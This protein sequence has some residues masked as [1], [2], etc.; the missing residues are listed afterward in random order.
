MT[1]SEINPYVR[2]ARRQERNFAAME[3]VALDHRIFMVEKGSATF[4]LNDV[5]YRAEKGDVVFWPAGV[6][7]RVEASEDAVVSGCNFDFRRTED[8]ALLPIFPVVA[9]N[10]SGQVLEKPD[11]PDATAF[12][13][14]FCVRN[15]YGTLPKLHELYEEFS[16][17]QIFFEQRCSALLQ[18]VLMLC[19]R[20]LSG[21]QA[22]TSAK[23]TQ[24]IL[25]YIKQHYNE[26][27]TNARFAQVFHY[28]PNY[29]SQLVKE[30]TGLPL[31]RYIRNYRIHA[32][33]ELLQTSELSV[34]QVAERVGIR[35]VH[36]FSKAFRRVIGTAP[37][38]FRRQ[39]GD[40]LCNDRLQYAQTEK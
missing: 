23:I 2:F 19:L 34:A 30:Q 6:R 5:S 17:K 24:Q 9:E 20:F 18:D 4:Y 22:E 15:T 36:Q 25:V 35:D 31:H 3:K 14:P 27:M 37:S 28:H 1:L 26:E 10:F 29:I 8:T 16:A 11:F 7:Y 39:S 33:L 38:S 32:A 21:N 40:T 12:C 13:A